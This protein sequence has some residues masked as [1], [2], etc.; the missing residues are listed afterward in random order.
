MLRRAKRSRAWGKL[1]RGQGLVE[2]ALIIMLVGVAVILA[3]TLFG[4]RV[5]KFY[6]EAVLALDP[7]IDAPACEGIFVSC[8]VTSTNPLN[9]EASVT[10]SVGD[11]NIDR[12]V[13]YVDDQYVRTEYYYIYC[14]GGGDG[15][16]GT[17]TRP[18]GKHKISAVAFDEDGNTGT[19]SVTATVK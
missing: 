7:N 14:L 8:H 10:D 6:C 17:I 16:C 11:N 3:L 2:Y 19:C 9:V 5:R 15:R 13:F 1:Q 18:P 12:V 4:D